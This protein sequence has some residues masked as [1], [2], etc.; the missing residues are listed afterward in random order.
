MSSLA[1]LDEITIDSLSSSISRQFTYSIH[2]CHCQRQKIGLMLVPKYLQSTNVILLVCRQCFQYRDDDF[3]AHLQLEQ[4][5]FRIYQDSDMFLFKSRFIQ[6]EDQSIEFQPFRWEKTNIE[7]R[8]LQRKEKQILQ[9][10][11]LRKLS[12][13]SS[14]S[15]W[16]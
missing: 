11:I 4:W 5:Y 16:S 12:S 8:D 7:E 10:I 2:N 15:S 13:S 9:R 6:N 1:L 14:S 3:S